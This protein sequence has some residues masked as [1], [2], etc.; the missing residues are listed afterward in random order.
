[1]SEDPKHKP[2]QHVPSF[3]EL[4][5]PKRPA[6]AP[7]SAELG[8]EEKTSQIDPDVL[9]KALAQSQVGAPIEPPTKPP[10][11]ALAASGKLPLQPLPTRQAPPPPGMRPTAPAPPPKWDDKT[12]N[13]A[14]PTDPVAPPVARAAP[15]AQ[16]P[17]PA[18]TVPAMPQI[19][20]QTAVSVAI[21]GRA[22]PPAPG[23]RAVPPA[24]SSRLTEK[25]DPVTPDMIHQA[26]TAAPR[27]QA[28]VQAAAPATAKLDPSLHQTHVSLPHQRPQKLPEPS[29]ASTTQSA[30]TLLEIRA[31][32]TGSQ[33]A[34]QQVT[35]P[36]AENPF[37][38]KRA[39]EPSSGDRP[40]APPLDDGADLEPPTKNERPTSRPDIAADIVSEVRRLAVT[41]SPTSPGVDAPAPAT[42]AAT[43][44][45]AVEVVAHPA[46]TFRLLA[47]FIIDGLVL[48]VLTIVLGF[49]VMAAG[50]APALPPGLGLLDQLAMRVSEV[51]KLVAAAAVLAAGLAAA[52]STLF[53]VALSGRT[54]GRLVAG[55]RLVDS[56]G[57]PPSALRSLARSL[58][59]LLSLALGGLGFWLGLFSAK[60][61]TLHDKLCST[62]VVRLGASRT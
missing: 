24:P 13:L 50:K 23:S 17:M 10:P 48:G 1:M 16:L 14:P 58:C 7:P 15:P 38:S 55:L 47:A 6:A 20:P 39:F 56:R 27:A 3:D 26:R 8:Q 61:Q 51:P 19:K 54:V 42:K 40:A 41:E 53:A 52:Y 35:Q 59:A 25:M 57:G 62:F 22:P 4:K 21:P 2:A 44:V 32:A 60:S 49:V 30:P 31:E 29:A 11:V 12:S 5:A 28:P 9:R 46:P 43:A 34:R 33:A 37:V 36:N 18:T 45:A